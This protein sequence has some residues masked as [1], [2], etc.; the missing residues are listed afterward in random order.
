MKEHLDRN[1]R[2]L[3]YE[4]IVHALKTEN[5]HHKQWYLQRIADVLDAVLTGI[6]VEEGIAP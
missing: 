1:E 2:A 3:V 5:V 4:L 6:D